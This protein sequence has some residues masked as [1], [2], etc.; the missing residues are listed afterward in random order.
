[1]KKYYILLSILF[2]SCQDISQSPEINFETN[3]QISQIGFPINHSIVVDNLGELYT[4]NHVAWEDSSFWLKD[5]SKV[6]ITQSNIDTMNNSI[7]FNYEIAFWDTGKVV[8]PPHYVSISFPDSIAPSV[9]KTDSSEVFIASV[10]DSTMTTVISDKPLKEIKFPI[11]RLRLFLTLLLIVAILYFI[12]LLK[13]RNSQKFTKRQF[14]NF[15]PKSKALK[16]VE[17]IDLDLS[18]N[19][20]Y[21]EIIEILRKYFYNNFYIISYEMTSM[22]LKNFFQDDELNILL[23]EIDQ[24]KFAKKSPSKSEKKD[25][26]ELLKKVIRKLL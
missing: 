9:F 19:E 5:S 3:P 6:I 4:I 10:F 11:E 26:L 22:E 8:I 21:D 20:F 18:V 2:F 23:D 7:L 16:D 1:M 25:I 12:Y 24:V 17:K 14:F 15:N 13:T